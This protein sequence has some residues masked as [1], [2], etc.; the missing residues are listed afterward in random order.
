MSE[1]RHAD[2]PTPER[3]RLW[4]LLAVGVVSLVLAALIAV[5]VLRGGDGTAA[6]A[7]TGSEPIVLAPPLNPTPAAAATAAPTATPAAPVTPAS[8]ATGP[9]PAAVQLSGQGEATTEPFSLEGGLLLVRVAHNGEAA[10]SAALV[11]AGDELVPLTEG[12]GEYRGVRALSVPAGDY[13]LAVT[14]DGVWA[15]SVEQPRYLEGPAAPVVVEGEGDAV[16]DPFRVTE[17]RPAGEEL[18]LEVETETGQGLAVRVLDVDGEVVAEVETADGT[19]GLP[20]V[21]PGLHLLDVRA[22]GIWRLVVR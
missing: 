6:P 18:A 2:A 19:A 11:D 17:D 1:E 4:L 5:L 3:E 22:D 15:A 10:F 16:T 21:P 14:A 13:R 8:V 7:P 20:G 9:G 12:V